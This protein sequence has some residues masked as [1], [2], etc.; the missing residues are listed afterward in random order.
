M[1]IIDVALWAGIIVGAF[2]LVGVV[3]AYFQKQHFGLGGAML[4]F[5]GVVLIGMS[6]WKTARLEVTPDGGFVAVLEQLEE[7]VRELDAELDTVD[8]AVRD[9]R[10]RTRAE[11]LSLQ[12][13][14]DALRTDL[15]Q[16]R[17]A[18]LTLPPS[19]M[20]PQRLQQLRQ[21][22]INPN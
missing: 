21:G 6:I 14:T 17:A 12:A 2:M 4:T 7:R 1:T 10:E 11:L 3:A 16:T 20:D 5:F 15:N 9:T 22:Q 8:A 19:V 18:V 13:T